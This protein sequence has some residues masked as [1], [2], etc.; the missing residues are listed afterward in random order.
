MADDRRR[1]FC[2]GLKMFALSRAVKYDFEDDEN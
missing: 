2:L 1:D